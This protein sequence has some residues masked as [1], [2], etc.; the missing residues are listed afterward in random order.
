ME[1][2][3]NVEHRR[4]SGKTVLITGAASGIGRGCAIAVAEAG[5]HVV[6]CDVDVA[7][8][9]QVAA[10]IRN[11]GGSATVLYID[12]TSEASIADAVAATEQAGQAIDG[13][14]NSAGTTGEGSATTSSLADWTRVIGINL[15]GTWQVCRAV[16][17][18]MI[19]RKAG[20]IVNIGSVAGLTGTPNNIAYSA[21]K[22]GVVSIT[23]QMAIDYALDGIRI[24]SICPG[25]ISTP[26]L[27]KK[28]QEAGFFDNGGSGLDK[29]AQR[30]PVRRLGDVSEVGNLAVFLLTDEAR[31]LTG[32]NVPLDGGLSAAGWLPGA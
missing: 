14:V 32:A 25:A 17:P 31:F 24:N 10:E 28:Y 13:L 26:L 3:D 4:L 22:G 30:Y 1:S 2:L 9:E 16:L 5:A 21:S 20:S 6:C 29:V 19:R 23:R 18:G 12:V 27:I 8:A 15:T 7:M 11:A